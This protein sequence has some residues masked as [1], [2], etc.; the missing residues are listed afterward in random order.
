MS[1]SHFAGSIPSSIGFLSSLKTLSLASNHFRGP[2]PE[3]VCNI[4]MLEQLNLSKNVLSG[5]FQLGLIF[6]GGQAFACGCEYPSI[7]SCVFLFEL[8]VPIIWLCFSFEMHNFTG[9]IP[10]SIERMPMLTALNL[11]YN[12]FKGK[13]LRICS[14]PWLDFSEN[15][16]HILESAFLRRYFLCTALWFL[17]FILTFSPLC[18]LIYRVHS[19]EHWA[20]VAAHRA[21]PGP[22]LLIRYVLMT[23]NPNLLFTYE[24]SLYSR[25]VGKIPENIGSLLELTALTITHNQ[26]SGEFLPHICV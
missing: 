10:A 18:L 2:F 9:Q 4:T 19:W 13:L 14:C 22:Q 6:I 20:T 3:S 24:V 7:Y 12:R 5:Q 11:A 17:Y 21:S 1:F 26:L 23:L 8:T 16:V 25:I 15:R